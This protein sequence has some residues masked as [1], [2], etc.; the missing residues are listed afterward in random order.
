MTKK[1][2]V[3]LCTGLVIVALLAAVYFVLIGTAPAN[4]V[5]TPVEPV[6]QKEYIVDGITEDNLYTITLY[7]NG[8]QQYVILKNLKVNEFFIQGLEHL[9]YTSSF[10]S[11]ISSVSNIRITE[12]VENPLADAEYGI[13]GQNSPYVLEFTALDGKTERIFIGLQT[14][15]G[16]EFYCKKDG[17]DEIVCVS[18]T[19]GKYLVEK[20][21]LLSKV[22]SLPL[23]SAKYFYTE[24]F[25]LYKDM[26]K[27]VSIEFVPKEQRPEG[28]VLGAYKMTYPAEYIPS[29]T[30]YDTVLKSLICP[31]TDVI[32]TTEITQEN[33]EKYGFTV[34]SYE[35][36]YTL[37]G[38]KRSIIFGNRTDDG[39]IYV[40]SA[41]FG[42]I[43]LVGIEQHFPF[44]DWE[45]I[46]YINPALF[47]MN[48]DYISSISV[49]GDGFSDKY[50]LSGKGD[51]LVVKNKDGTLVDTHNFRQFYRVFLM[52]KMEGYADTKKTDNHL[53]TYVIETTDGTVY[54]YSFY[55]TSTRKCYYTVGGTGEFYVSVDVVNKLISD[56]AKLSTGESI[57]ADSQI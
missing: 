33:L 9:A 21:S 10:E 47:S 51:A 56:A 38:I 2:F 42:F 40:L 29:D 53:L 43:G 30:D 13:S 49:S 11:L 34:P 44:L 32:V 20:N 3:L 26:R 15:S 1:K 27:F 8:E 39:L 25:E 5:E 18:S 14:A 57:N 24:S 55:Q 35:I 28:S 17:S 12:K 7:K 45:L 36:Y 50:T 4:D 37:D 48:I 46:T 52:A 41:D 16:S 19:I 31:E 23:D 6:D 22:L 54:E